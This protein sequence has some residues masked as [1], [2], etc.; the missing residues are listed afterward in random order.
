MKF[1]NIPDARRK[2]GLS[3]IGKVNHSSKHEKA[4]HYN[5][6]VYTIY[7]AP[8]NMSGYEVCPMRSDECTKLCLNESGRNRMDIHVNKINKSRI[9]KQNCFLKNAN[10][11]LDGFLKKSN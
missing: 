11:L 1:L 3:Y 5:E 9:T 7:L 10:F 8:A 6:L 2:S 4:Y